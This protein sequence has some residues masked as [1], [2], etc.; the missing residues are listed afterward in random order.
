MSAVSRYTITPRIAF[1]KQYGTSNTIANIRSAIKEG[2]IQTTTIFLKEAIRL[3]VLAGQ[4]YNDGRYGWLIAA[5]SEIGWM[6]QTPPNTRI[7]IPDLEQSLR[8]LG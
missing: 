3:D 1:G 5:A 6:P 2:K 8:Y 4:Y 7:V